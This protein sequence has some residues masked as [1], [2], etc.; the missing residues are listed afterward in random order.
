MRSFEFVS[1]KNALA[2]IV[3]RRNS[4]LFFSSAMPFVFVDFVVAAFCFFFC[5]ISVHSVQVLD[6]DEILKN[7]KKVS[8]TKCDEQ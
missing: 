1:A 3:V 7:K 6:L 8:R 2:M 4:V 5:S